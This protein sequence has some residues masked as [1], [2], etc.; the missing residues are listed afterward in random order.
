[1]IPKIIHQTWKDRDLPP[2]LSALQATWK[3]Y[4]PDWEYVFWTDADNRNFLATHY[5]WFLPIYDGYSHSICR[6]DA[7]RYFWLYHYG[8]V[9]VDL[10]FECL[11]PLDPL[12]ADR[13]ILLSLE[14][15]AHTIDNHQAQAQN[16]SQILSPALMASVIHHPFW[17][18]IWQQLF[19]TKDLIDPCSVTGPF[20]L[21][22]AYQSYPKSSDIIP[23]ASA[24]LHPIT[25]DRVDRG[26]LF[27]LAVR[28]EISKQALGIH[29]WYGSWW[30]QHQAQI[31]AILTSNCSLCVLDRGREIIVAK[32][33]NRAYRTLPDAFDTFPL[34]SCLMVTKNRAELA[35][36]AIFCFLQQTYIRKEL[37][38]IDDSEDDE[39]AEFVEQFPHPQIVYYRPSA[40]LLTVDE[41]RDI[42]IATAT[43]TYIAHWND[44]DLCDPLRLELQMSIVRAFKVDACFLDRVYAWWPHQQRLARSVRRVWEG[45]LMCR[46]EILPATLS[47]RCG[48]VTNVLT[49]IL[50]N[51]RVAAIDL[52]ELYVY[53]VHQNNTCSPENLDANWQQAQVRFEGNDYVKMLQNFT[54]RLPIHTYLQSLLR[55]HK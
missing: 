13:S 43:G 35:K 29:H 53:S 26:Q 21:T 4:H 2:Y 45:T 46:K 39:L 42:S 25:L 51:Y 10:D 9:Y 54:V 41:L 6:V 33:S 50:E 18:Y 12:L 38:I 52:P 24:I 44:A 11:S 55:Y 31:V 14:P 20:F 15:S 5:P 7:I 34:I 48:E 49:S 32:F 30:K 1:M 8:G 22:H 40:E 37:V 19:K 47:Q 36:R 16:L 28:A 17:E 23:I 27:S 3:E